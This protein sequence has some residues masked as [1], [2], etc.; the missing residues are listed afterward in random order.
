MVFQGEFSD[1]R[2]G[3]D[4]LIDHVIVILIVSLLGLNDAR[5]ISMVLS[6]VCL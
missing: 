2:V 4:K 3:T 6:W 5:E 1:V